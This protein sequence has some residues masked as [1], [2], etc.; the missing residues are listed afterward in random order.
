MVWAQFILWPTIRLASPRILGT[1]GPGASA[2][3][4]DF[5]KVLL[6]QEVDLRFLKELLMMLVK[7]SWYLASKPR[8]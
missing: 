7:Y 2:S 5:N 6:L 8:L 3:V 1:A 4:D